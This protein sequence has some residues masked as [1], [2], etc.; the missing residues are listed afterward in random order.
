[1][2]QINA[3]VFAGF[4]TTHT[5]TFLLATLSRALPYC[6]KILAFCFKRSFLSIPGPL[7]L[8]PTSIAASTSLNPY[9]RSVLGT[10]E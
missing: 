3:F 9:T 7:G 5:F 1:M 2:E 8:A 4:P 10:I 6:L